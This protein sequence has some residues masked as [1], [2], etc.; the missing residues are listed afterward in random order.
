MDGKYRVVPLS[1]DEEYIFARTKK[2]NGQV[3]LAN[4]KNADIQC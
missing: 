2:K 1:K 4:V 3:V